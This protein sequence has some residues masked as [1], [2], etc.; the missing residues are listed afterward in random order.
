[1]ITIPELRAIAIEAYK[2]MTRMP[3]PSGP[4]G[5]AGYWPE[6][7]GMYADERTRYRVIPKAYEISR[8]DKLFDAINKLEREGERRAIFEWMEIQCSKRMTIRGEAQKLGLLEHQYRKSID[9][10]FQ[11]VAV[12]YNINPGSMSFTP[13]EH[14]DETGHNGSTSDEARP[15]KQPTHWLE[16]GYKPRASDEVPQRQHHMKAMLARAAERM[17]EAQ[18]RQR[19]E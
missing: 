4:A 6:Y 1:M 18:G 5:S 9:G 10:I 7:P 19:V 15:A 11:K 16:T 8:M 3:K 13:V 12:H 14:Y 17:G 2:T